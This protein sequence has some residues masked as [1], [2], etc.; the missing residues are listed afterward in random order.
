ML[1]AWVILKTVP[2]SVLWRRLKI[3][4][5]FL[6]FPK[7]LIHSTLL[8]NDTLCLGVLSTSGWF[9]PTL[10]ET[11][12]HCSYPCLDS[13]CEYKLAEWVGRIQVVDLLESW[14]VC[15]IE[16]LMWSPAYGM[17][18]SARSL[19]VRD[20]WAPQSSSQLFST[21]SACSC[22]LPSSL[23]SRPRQ[24]NMTFCSSMSR[25]WRKGLTSWRTSWRTS[26]GASW[27]KIFFFFFKI[28]SLRPS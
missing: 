3:I 19:P 22:L 10:P 16:L 18:H 20:T 21:S 6:L 24:K 12:K 25:K 15:A 27:H 28:F 7:W 8:S 2:E 11:R 14:T 23:C 1:S 9:S 17:Q 5:F 13:S 4:L 26:W